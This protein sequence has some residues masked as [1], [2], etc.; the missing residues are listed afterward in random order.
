MHFTIRVLPFR[1]SCVST[2]IALRALCGSSMS[3]VDACRLVVE[4]TRCLV[5]QQ[6]RWVAGQPN[7]IFLREIGTWRVS[8]GV[9]RRVLVAQLLGASLPSPMHRTLR[10]SSWRRVF[11]VSRWREA[12]QTIVWHSPEA[13]LRR[14]GPHATDPGDSV[15]SIASAPRRS[16]PA[17]RGCPL[18]PCPTQS[19][20]RWPSIDE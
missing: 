16:V 14:A 4:V 15:R 8:Q 7:R 3:A 19:E 18:A 5:R 10:K 9:V 13:D 12:G 17:P 2:Q 1:W 20:N 11:E 6:D